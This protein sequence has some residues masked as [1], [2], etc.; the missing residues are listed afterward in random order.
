M[1][2]RIVYNLQFNFPLD[3][4]TRSRPFVVGLH[5]TVFRRNERAPTVSIRCV[6]DCRDIE[7][8]NFDECESSCYDS[9]VRLSCVYR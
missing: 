5:R 1:C 3:E 9:R 7:S 4:I 6:R 8:E 2:V